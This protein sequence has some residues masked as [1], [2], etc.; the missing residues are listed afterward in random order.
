MGNGDGPRNGL[1]E[2]CLPGRVSGLGPIRFP[3]LPSCSR[4]SYTTSYMF[5][6]SGREHGLGHLWDS[7]LSSP[8]PGDHSQLC[9]L[10]A[11]TAQTPL[12]VHLAITSASP[13]ATAPHL[14]LCI[15]SSHAPGC[16]P[17]LP[18]QERNTSHSP[19]QTSLWVRW[20]WR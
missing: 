13:E 12:R 4:L 11:G 1:T 18:S 5:P 3:N 20:R 14:S 15:Q 16:T 9:S 7:C 2:E 19:S 17:V 10:L 6:P 8:H